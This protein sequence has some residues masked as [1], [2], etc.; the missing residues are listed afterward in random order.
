[1]R[2]LCLDTATD[3]GS[4]AVVV[5][6]VPRVERATK[7]HARLGETLLG[8]VASALAEAGIEPRSLELC[9]VGTGPGSFTGLRVGLA[10][11][12][13]LHL[14]LGIPL[15]GIPSPRTLARALATE[16][17]LVAIDARKDE[18]FITC[19]RHVG[20][21]LEVL[22][23]DAHGPFAAMGARARAVLGPDVCPTL[24]GTGAL[25]ALEAA[26]GAPFVRAPAE[27]DRPRAALMAREAERRFLASGG[28]DP[29]ALVP[30][31]VR[32]ADVTLKP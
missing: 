29:A 9:A 14:G 31:Y 3:M 19:F 1:M 4:V 12:K 20:D 22:L 28:D 32:G 6:G 11:A 21:E 23:D 27:L 26:L 16:T 7:I 8:E 18:A 5:D 30:H 25:P 24:V 13:G 2:V 17:S 10:M 15:V